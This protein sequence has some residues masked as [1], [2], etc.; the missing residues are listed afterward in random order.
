MFGIEQIKHF[1]TDVLGTF[2]NGTLKFDSHRV[3]GP[4]REA[5]VFQG[6]GGGTRALNSCSVDTESLPQLVKDI[7][8]LNS[9]R[10]TKTIDENTELAKTIITLRLKLK[11]QIQETA[12]KIG[13]IDKM[14]LFSRIWY[15]NEIK[16]VREWNKTV[17]VLGKELDDLY[18]VKAVD[19]EETAPKGE[20]PNANA[21]LAIQRREGLMGRLRLE[22][23]LN[24][25]EEEATLLLNENPSAEDLSKQSNL[26]AKL[27]GFIIMKRDD[28]K[29]ELAKSQ[30]KMQDIMANQDRLGELPRHIERHNKLVAELEKLEYNNLLAA[31][32]PPVEKG[33]PKPPVKK[34]FAPVAD[35]W[36]T[37]NCRDGYEAFKKDWRGF[38]ISAQEYQLLID[39]NPHEDQIEAQNKLKV[40]FQE[41][42]VVTAIR[43]QKEVQEHK[44]VIAEAEA[45]EHDYSR[46]LGQL[47]SKM[48]AE[49]Y[50]IN[51][52]YS[53]KIV[54]TKMAHT[55]LG[56]L[57]D[58]GKDKIAS[59]EAEQRKA[60]QENAV[61]YET[62]T[63]DGELNRVRA[64][65]KETVLPNHR[66]ALDE[67]KRF[68]F[69]IGPNYLKQEA[70]QGDNQPKGFLDKLRALGARML[71][72]THKRA[73]EP[74]IDPS[75][76]L[77]DEEQE[78]FDELST[79]GPADDLAAQWKRDKKEMNRFQPKEERRDIQAARELSQNRVNARR[80]VRQ[81][82]EA[83]RK[84][85][86]IENDKGAEDY[87]YDALNS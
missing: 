49:E 59:L 81:A 55:W 74:Q 64:H 56:Y 19:L 14:G 1:S 36:I 35:H 47:T 58:E 11:C 51:Q 79:Y 21:W 52:E 16:N 78:I 12:D 18:G 75:D 63:N 15:R 53:H 13:D 27:E 43:L 41:L 37:H 26:K 28:L 86:A 87:L 10:E 60:L 62:F 85:A 48:Q 2:S 70:P 32:P 30:K 50:R 46:R 45:F 9:K 22:G 65:L 31:V 4:G 76:A 29:D 39:N 5:K 84:A 20:T 61:K 44:K 71:S 25:S 42:I 17:D 68:L 69:L 7:Q 54:R 8:V 40:R 33:E 73:Q 24:I 67:K 34:V 82:T 38:N 3:A 83:N 66:K 6:V 23:D 77:S 57:T 72:P 80:A